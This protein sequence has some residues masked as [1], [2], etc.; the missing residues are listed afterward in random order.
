MTS[1]LRRTKFCCESR[2]SLK[3]ILRVAALYR[4]VLPLALH[5]A[6]AYANFV[7]D[8]HDALAG[9]QL[10]LDALFKLLAYPRPTER[11]ARLHSALEP[12]MDA[13]TDHAALELRK[14][15]G[16]LKHQLAHWRSRVDGLLVE[17]Q[18]NA[19]GPKLLD[20]VEQ[21]NERTAE[22]IN[23]PGH[24]NIEFASLGITEH[25][26]KARTAIAAFAAG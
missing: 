6:I 11:L 15:A 1:T 12:C 18:I 21:V 17:V 9:P 16:D 24:H 10:I 25:Q 23:R 8:L 13:L 5:G 26:V 22:P 19:G 20:R 7:S 14:S 3:P 2:E 4:D